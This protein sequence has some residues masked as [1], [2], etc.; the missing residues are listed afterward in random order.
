MKVLALS[1]IAYNVLASSANHPLSE[2]LLFGPYSSLARKYLWQSLFTIWDSSLPAKLRVIAAGRD[3]VDTGMDKIWNMITLNTTC[4]SGLPIA[5]DTCKR[6]K[7]AF[8]SDI[9]YV[10]IRDAAGYSNLGLAL[11]AS[12]SDPSF[13]GRVTYFS[14]DTSLVPSLLHSLRVHGG[15]RLG[16]HAAGVAGG[17][18]PFSR[19]IVEKP[20]GNDGSSCKALLR[21]LQSELGISRAAQAESETTEGEPGEELQKEERTAKD[22]GVLLIMDHYLGK[23]GLRL[24]YEVRKRITHSTPWVSYLSEGLGHMEVV[25]TEEETAEGRTGF[26]NGV[27]VLRDMLQSHVSLFIAAAIGPRKSPWNA[28]HRLKAWSRLQPK[29][30]ALSHRPYHTTGAPMAAQ[31]DEADW[32]N[33]NGWRPT[34]ASARVVQR[35][36]SEAVT[37][38]I[39]LARY[40]GYALHV[41]RDRAPG[42]SGA[43][44][45]NVTHSRWCY[46]EQT[47]AKSLKLLPPASCVDALGGARGGMHMGGPYDWYGPGYRAVTGMD[48]Q[49]LVGQGTVMDVKISKATGFRTAYFRHTARNARLSGCGP[50]SIT[51]HM[52]GRVMLPPGVNLTDV[53]DSELPHNAP[54]VIFTGICSRGAAPPMSSIVDNEELG[55]PDDWE[56]RRVPAAGLWWATPKVETWTAAWPTISARTVDMRYAVEGFL[57][58]MYKLSV[59]PGRAGGDAYTGMIAA[60]LAGETDGYLTPREAR[61]LWDVWQGVISLS[62]AAAAGPTLGHALELLAAKRA[63]NESKGQYQVSQATLSPLDDPHTGPDVPSEVVQSFV[64]KFKLPALPRVLEHA[65]GDASWMRLLRAGAEGVHAAPMAGADSAIRVFRTDVQ[66]SVVDKFASDIIALVWSSTSSASDG[67]TGVGSGGKG[68]GTK[69]KPATAAGIR[70]PHLAFDYPV[71]GASPLLDVLYERLA[72]DDVSSLVPWHE[73]HVWPVRLPVG[74]TRSTGGQGS[75]QRSLLGPLGLTLGEQYHGPD[76]ASAPDVH[77]TALALSREAGQE[78][79]QGQLD[80]VVLAW[81]AL[82]DGEDIQG[83]RAR[84]QSRAHASSDSDSSPYVIRRTAHGTGPTADTLIVSQQALGTA[85]HVYIVVSQSVWDMYAAGASSSLSARVGAEGGVEAHGPPVGDVPSYSP[86]ASVP[87]A[88]AQDVQRVAGRLAKVQLYVM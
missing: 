81:Q 71:E 41:T 9:Q 85:R 76:S 82:H 36:A 3:N 55:W 56:Q 58:R 64:R 68:S 60:A 52:Q 15:V 44:S 12:S 23:T 66:G 87:A 49:L 7:E 11:N 57:A 88:L 21:A 5:G 63:V 65:V 32:E 35:N 28:E 80:G 14:V 78:W 42:G 73:V 31:A 79:H 8:R 86:F 74:S 34:P 13:I 18:A 25:V 24:A 6:M 67:G 26:Y 51:F 16:A 4:G 22:N 2:V 27:G 77:A 45:H 61:T 19:V 50:V 59:T 47:R 83:Y 48:V 30:V 1:Y 17:E 62:D 75:L 37:H 10:Q 84:L 46:L 39:R 70:A 53:D 69:D 33:V 43:F 29:S 20:L 54:A 72:E 40:A 38:A